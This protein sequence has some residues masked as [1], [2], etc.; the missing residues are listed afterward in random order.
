MACA[1]P[2]AGDRHRQMF[3]A[4]PC[5]AEKTTKPPAHCEMWG[6]RSS[7]KE[8]PCCRSA[9]AMPVRWDGS[10][11][12]ETSHHSAEVV[13]SGATNTSRCLLSALQTGFITPARSAA[14]G[15]AWPPSEG[16]VELATPAARH[17]RGVNSTRPIS[18]PSPTGR[19]MRVSTRRSQPGNFTAD[20]GDHAI[21]P[22]S[23]PE[24]KTILLPSGENEGCRVSASS[25]V[26]C[27]ALP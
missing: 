14:I 5:G 6:S 7:P 17:D 27:T 18:D 20:C 13:T 16:D 21:A 4:S 3:T 8:K 1:V 9:L 26:S 12:I 2:R 25:R 10:S 22:P 15:R 19:K 24:R 11:L 23:R